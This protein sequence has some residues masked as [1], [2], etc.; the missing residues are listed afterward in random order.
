M[1][2]SVGPFQDVGS[3]CRCA[4]KSVLCLQMSVTAEANVMDTDT[5]LQPLQ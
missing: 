3:I 1:F 2:V 5:F 4:H